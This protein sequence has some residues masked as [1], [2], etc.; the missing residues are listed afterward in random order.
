[1]QRSV[2]SLLLAR[3]AHNGAEQQHSGRAGVTGVCVHAQGRQAGHRVRRTNSDPGTLQRHLARRWKNLVESRVRGRRC[4][5][6]VCRPQRRG[7]L[8][9]C[10]AGSV[11]L[12]RQ[13]RATPGDLQHR[14]IL[15]RV[16]LA[17]VKDHVGEYDKVA[18][19]LKNT[20][21]KQQE[22][23]KRMQKCA[24]SSG[25]HCQEQPG[26]KGQDACIAGGAPR[27]A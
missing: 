26:S 10:P 13:L 4:H 8:C 17:G 7:R 25:C 22:S 16:H 3:A 23:S 2:L 14:S 11:A 20:R 5:G 27:N 19:V 15:P 12:R 1:M 21:P 24:A 6:G 9:G 18:K